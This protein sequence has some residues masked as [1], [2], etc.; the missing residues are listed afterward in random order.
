MRWTDSIVTRLIAWLCLGGLL[1]SS[2]YSILEYDHSMKQI[3]VAASQ[4]LLVLSHR[5]QEVR[6]EIPDDKP[7]SVRTV[8]EIFRQDPRLI[9]TRIDRPDGDAIMAGILT[10]DL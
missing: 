2:G 5:L 3:E 1:L 4:E 6:G 8:L 7:E 9:A 10:E